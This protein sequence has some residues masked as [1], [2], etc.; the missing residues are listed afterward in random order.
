MKQKIFG[1]TTLLFISMWSYAQTP[2]TQKISLSQAIE[3]ADK[4]RYDLKAN[5]MDIGIAENKIQKS[6]NQWLPDISA[7]TEVRYN[8]QLQKM[9][10]DFGSGIEK[11]DVGTKNLTTYNLDLAQPIFKPGLQADI[12]IAKADVKVEREKMREKENNIKLT[13]AEAYLNVILKEKQWQ[14]ARENTE[15]YN[16]YYTLATDRFALKTIIESDLLKARTDYENAKITEEETHQNYLLALKNLKYQLNIDDATTLEL[17]DSLSSLENVDVTRLNYHDYENRPELK[18]LLYSQE[19][20]RLRIKKENQ[21][22]LPTVSFVANYTNQFQAGNFNYT[23]N[24]WSPYNYVGVKASVP[25]TELFKRGAEAKEYKLKA[26]QLEMQYLQKQQD[27]AYE[28]DKNQTELVNTSNNITATN[29]TLKLSQDLYTNQFEIFK[30]GGLT[31]TTLL[32]TE[33]SI[34]TA[35]DN[36]I[37]AVYNFLIAYYNYKKSTSFQPK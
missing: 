6:K 8:T 30:L 15:R 4:N 13:V 9:V 29:R 25:I 10:L 32:E 2:S 14:I 23:Q 19:A 7:G 18:Q 26:G 33:A 17:T 3:I 36:Y 5:N 21:I 11:I 27:I 34:K 12:S 1:I 20:N 37:K 28:M 31:Y 22:W 24:L 35:Q 16:A